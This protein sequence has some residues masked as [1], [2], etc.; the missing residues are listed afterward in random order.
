MTFS[1]YEI[2]CLIGSGRFG[3]VYKVREKETNGVFA[4]K[5]LKV[6]ATKEG[7]PLNYIREIKYVKYLENENIIH[8]YDITYENNNINLIFEYIKFNLFDII[9][10]HILEKLT[11]EHR[12]HLFYQIMKGLNFLHKNNIMHRDIKPSNLLVTDDNIVKIID[13]GIS[14]LHICDYNS[15][16]VVTL[17]YRAPELLFKGDLYNKAIDIWSAGCILFELLTGDVLFYNDCESEVIHAENIFG[18]LEFREDLPYYDRIKDLFEFSE[19]EKTD[20]F[21][22]ES[23]KQDTEE[24]DLL[25]KMLDP[26]PKRRITADNVLEHSLFKSI[27]KDFSTYPTLQSLST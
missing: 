21:G 9:R 4:L 1:N 15:C 22:D 8:L 17:Q 16:N 2:K 11:R 23:I 7:I 3:T 26:D 10:S 27:N 19:P 13:F 20:F 25:V 24:Y 18:L 6:T 12:L 5:Q 14:K